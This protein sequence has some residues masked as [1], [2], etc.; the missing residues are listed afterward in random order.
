MMHA[1]PRLAGARLATAISSE[2]GGIRALSTS[3]AQC[4]R[5]TCRALEH[6]RALERVRAR[7]RRP[8]TTTS[9]R[10]WR[11][12]SARER[13]PGSGRRRRRRRVAGTARRCPAPAR[14]QPGGR[15]RPP[16]TR[17]SMR[18]RP[19]P[20]VSRRGESARRL[21]RQPRGDVPV[22]PADRG[23]AA[24]RQRRR[25]ISRWPV[26]DEP[27]ELHALVTLGHDLVFAGRMSEGWDLSEIERPAG[28]CVKPRSGGCTRLPVAR[29][30]RLGGGRLRAIRT[31]VPRGDRVRRAGRTLER[32][33]L[34]G[35]APRTG[36]LGDRPVER[37]AAGHG[38]GAGGWPGRCDHADHG[39]LR[40][41]VRG[42]GSAG[43]GFEPGSCWSESLELG[44]PMR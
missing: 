37:G 12:A 40:H 32:S 13:L 43:T 17:G 25:G 15:A 11:Y 19:R 35:G 8:A 10:P 2:P 38:A 20:T 33:P 24:P 44:R 41:G 16:A 18:W 28:S 1:G 42:P 14:G 26:N 23:V 31:L 39:P 3:A 9:P 6:A 29:L 27:T 5:A 22:R 34:H 4:A 21:L 7:R 30:G 36:L